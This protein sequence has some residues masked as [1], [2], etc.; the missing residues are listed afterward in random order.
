MAILDFTKQEIE[1][2]KSKIY[3]TELQEKILD[4][5]LKGDLTEYGMAIK[6]GVSESTIT[7][8][9]KKTKKKMLKVI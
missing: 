2:I 8:Q 4:M 7:Y 6:L 5:K 9:W 1:E 3:L